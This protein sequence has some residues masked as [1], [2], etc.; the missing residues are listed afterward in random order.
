MFLHLSVIHSVN[1]GGACV[2]GE[3]ECVWLRRGMCVAGQRLCM[4]WGGMHGWGT[5]IARGMYG[6]GHA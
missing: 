1:G 6:W 5:C 4:A 3:G 2:A